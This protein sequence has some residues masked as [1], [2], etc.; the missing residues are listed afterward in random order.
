LVPADGV[1]VLD[2][3]LPEHFDGVMPPPRDFLHG[4]GNH[5]EIHMYRKHTL[6][7]AWGDP[8]R[9]GIGRMLFSKTPQMAAATDA[10]LVRGKHGPAHGGCSSGI[11]W[12][13][14]SPRL[15]NNSKGNRI[16]QSHQK[17]ATAAGAARWTAR[18]T[19]REACK[20]RRNSRCAIKIQNARPVERF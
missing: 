14:S 12:R 6:A 11:A 3:R 20:G 5:F 15:A 13:W 19:A 1:F 4:F 16:L 9:R 18:K 2:R 7:L 17:T 10:H 8:R